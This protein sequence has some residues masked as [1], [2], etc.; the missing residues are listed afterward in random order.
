MPSFGWGV[1]PPFLEVNR[2]VK[3]PDCGLGSE[4]AGGGRRTEI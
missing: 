4:A 3:T 1:L 2:D